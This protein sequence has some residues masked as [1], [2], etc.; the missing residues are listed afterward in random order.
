MG[1]SPSCTK[2]SRPKVGEHPTNYGKVAFTILQTADQLLPQ[3]KDQVNKDLALRVVDWI[4]M[5]GHVNGALSKLRRSQMRPARKTEFSSICN[6]DI[7]NAPLLF[8]PDLSKKLKEA[9][10]A[11][12]IGRSLSNASRKKYGS[13]RGG[14]TI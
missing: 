4:A 12:D 10:E 13:P 8:G 9:K 2:V 5:L 11:N 1:N 7:T 14:G 3:T 6:A